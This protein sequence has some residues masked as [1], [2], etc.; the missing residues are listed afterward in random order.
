MSDTN[1]ALIKTLYESGEKAP[2][3][4]R[5]MGGH[6]SKQAIYKRAK[7]ED[8]VNPES[9]RETLERLPVPNTVWDTLS[10]K[11]K[12]VIEAFALGAATIEEAAA[13]ATVNKSTVQR[14]K[15]DEAFAAL[16]QTARLQARDE[17]VNNIKRFGEK[18]WRPNAFLL[19]R[20]W[21]SEFGQNQAIV[22]GHTFNVLGS[23]NL[24]ID[25]S[26]ERNVID[27]QPAEDT[28]P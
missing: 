17:L 5:S 4:S 12:I 2:D 13:R 21:K 27:V 9:T 11:Q 28:A 25:R 3:I 22:Q 26:E 14:W 24:G 18:E 6:P 16:C 20:L 15:K 23:I 1:W 10:D 8:W 7:K 19:E